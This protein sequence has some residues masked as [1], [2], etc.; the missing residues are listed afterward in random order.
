MFIDVPGAR[1]FASRSGPT[2]APAIVSIGG[3][4]G[5]SELWLDP[6]AVLSDTFCT[7][8]YDHRGAGL[9]ICDASTITFD[10][11]VA[12]AVAVMDAFQIE[13]CTLAAESAGAQTAL[14]VA[15]RYPERVD[16]LVIVDGMYARGVPLENDP[17]LAGLR[18]N[19]GATIERFVQL[20]VS[21][22]DSGHIRSWGRHILARA[23]QEAAIALRI[24]G[25]NTDVSADILRVKQPCL[26]IHGDEDRIV[27][28]ERGEALAAMLPG[29]RFVRLTGAG[30]VPT[31]TRPHEV[32]AAMREFLC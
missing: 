29:S 3:W 1:I 22:P 17:F 2:D 15:A 12:D 6:L 4:I 31:L 25:S 27:P 24:V 16:N 10:N 32:A 5:S 13:R 18:S 26:I 28:I 21:E 9:T 30:H 20:C 8:A 19:Y 11:L 23:S 7:V 14:A